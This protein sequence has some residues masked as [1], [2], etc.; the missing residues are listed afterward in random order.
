MVFAQEE[1]PLDHGVPTASQ[2]GAR[3][4]GARRQT[5]PKSAG[6]ELLPQP[7]RSRAA[8]LRGVGCTI[9][10]AFDEGLQSWRC[11]VELPRRMEAAA[12]TVDA[13]GRDQAVA[14]AFQRAETALGWRG[15]AGTAGGG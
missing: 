13:R 7:L 14:G 6:L 4:L 12:V 3:R 11:V 2:N 5:L 1:G 8:S 10:L 15:T 9:A